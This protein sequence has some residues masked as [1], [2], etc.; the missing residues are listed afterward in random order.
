[1]TVVCAGCGEANPDGFRFCG[2]CGAPLEEREARDV[3]KV[4]TVL[5]ADVVGS[6]ALGEERDPEAVRA[7][8][9]RY[10][11][12]ARAVI[13]RH[14]GT[15]EKFIG[16]AVMAVF[17]VPQAHEDDALRA[18]RAAAEL[19]ESLADGDVQVRVG[20]N[21]GEVVAGEGGTLVTGD[22]VNVAARLEQAAEPGE[23]LLGPETLQLV[24]DAVRAEPAGGL[25]LKGKAL[26]VTA[27]KLI[28]VDA[29]APGFARRLDSPLVGRRR[30]L[31]RLRQDFERATADSACH[32]FTL[33]GPAG[34]GKSRLVAE[35]VEEVGA[36]ARVLHG[37]CLHY[38][39]GITYWPLVE[40]LLQLGAD[41]ETILGLPSPTEASV[42]TRKLFEA[43]AARRPL[44]LVFDDL[45]WAEPTFLDL[46]EHVV[47]WSRDASIFLLG[48]ARPELL[49]V[50]PAWGGGKPNATM[51][52]LEALGETE[53]ETLIANLLGTEELADETR[54]RIV[55]A[56][57]GNPLFVEEMLLMLREHGNGGE[58]AVP[59]TIRALLQARIDRL[60]TEERAVVER[61]AIEGQVFHRS[62]VAE[63]APPPV[64]SDLDGHLLGLVRKELIRPETATIPGDDAFRFRHLLIRDAA[65]E[66]LPKE[67][68]AELH[69]RFGDWLD[70]H[71]ELVEQDEI[72]GYHLE[73]AVLYRAELGRD[74]ERLAVRAAERLTAAGSAA[75]GRGDRRAG[76]GLLER[77]VRLLPQGHPARLPALP[78]LAW[79]LTEAG[80]FEEAHHFIEEL[81]ET[82]D[83]RWN[84]YAAVVG[85]YHGALSGSGSVD[86]GRLGFAAARKTFE[87]L[88][89]DVGLGRA[90]FMEGGAEWTACRAASSIEFLRAALASAERAGDAALLQDIWAYLIG[91]YSLGPMPVS[92]AEREIRAIVETSPGLLVEAAAHRALARLAAM[93]GDFEAARSLIRRGRDPLADAGLAVHHAATSQGAAFVEALAGDREAAL[94]IAS[95]GFDRLSKLGE[96]AYAS[97]SAAAIGSLLCE[98]GRDDESEHWVR[99][100]RELSPA[101]DASTL[102]SVDYVEAILRARGGEHA[103]AERL[104][105]RAVEQSEGTDFW[106]HRGGAYEALALVLAAAGRRD[107]AEEARQAAI[108]I[109]DEK[110]SVVSA[111]RASTLLAEL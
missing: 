27:A 82:G 51:I 57:E 101:A 78:Q 11:E 98:L 91:A 7:L 50:R 92:E 8:M 58:V 72:V 22:A 74:D 70:A 38:G 2:S 19:R 36:R 9:S 43:E 45:Q 104:A 5:F 52:L 4:V 15:V 13:D 103:E 68:R 53:A 69:E 111:E 81:A 90:L 87:E 62:P 26:P 79:T 59:P 33:L 102:I 63:L 41:P 89:D 93:R 6:T 30:E 76:S 83:A 1:M 17:G 60:A 29:A 48:V 47:D 88:G 84:A 28:A 61:G 42:A 110:G 108:R 64:R 18:V 46:L 66:S 10:F 20:V 21:T 97:T 99:T 73:Q 24:R 106:E 95:E 86:A 80:R 12:S 56:S 16:D 100:A 37:R 23:V 25:D 31:E 44:V 77:A 65:Y 96:H 105:R 71:V 54:D 55:R 14:G 67:T 75:L 109:Y 40:V 3:R 39:E 49:E 107:E 32:L 94:R 35:F 34:V 85:P